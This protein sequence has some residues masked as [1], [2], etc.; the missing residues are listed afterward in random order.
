MATMYYVTAV[1]V[2]KGTSD[3]EAL[4]RRARTDMAKYFTRKDA[5]RHLDGLRGPAFYDLRVEERPE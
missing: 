1:A 5:E 2:P 4:S 3:Y